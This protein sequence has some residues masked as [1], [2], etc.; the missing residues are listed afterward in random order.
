[1]QT[2]TVRKD[3]DAS[4]ERVSKKMQVI[5]L[6]AADRQAW[7]DLTRESVRRLAQAAFPR[8]LVE[9]IAS[10]AGQPL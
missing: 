8:P 9:K 4:Y 7:G 3:D 5:E 6:D 10:L 1:V 2:K